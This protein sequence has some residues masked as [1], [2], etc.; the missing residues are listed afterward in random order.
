M[1]RWERMAVLDARFVPVRSGT[2]PMRRRRPGEVSFPWPVLGVVRRGR[3][4]V[5]DDPPREPP[6][7]DPPPG[8]V[9]AHR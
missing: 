3:R 4:V 1:T 9:P 6:F 5:A 7:D 8:A 2:G